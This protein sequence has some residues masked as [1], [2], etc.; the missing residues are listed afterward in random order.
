MIVLQTGTDLSFFYCVRFII[1]QNR[2]YNIFQHN[3][4]NKNTNS[5]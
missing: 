2:M 4:V 3:L 5:T 1:T